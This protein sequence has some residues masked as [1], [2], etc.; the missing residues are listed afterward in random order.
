MI[1]ILVVLYNINHQRETKEEVELDT[2]AQDG[3]ERVE[4]NTVNH[5]SKRVECLRKEITMDMWEQYTSHRDL[6]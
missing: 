1:T 5:G 6:S 4:S 3:A 2:T